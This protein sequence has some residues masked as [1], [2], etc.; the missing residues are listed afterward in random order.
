MR[1]LILMLATTTCLASHAAQ[2]QQADTSGAS[3]ADSSEIVVTPQNRLKQGAHAIVNGE[4]SWTSEDKRLRLSLWGRN[5]TDKT[6]GLYV[7]D[8]LGGDSAAYARPRSGGI[9]AELSF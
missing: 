6:Y 1:K 8:A 7:V 9:R 4:V 5:L 2:A 3:A